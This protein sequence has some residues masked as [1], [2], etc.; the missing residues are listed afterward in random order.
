MEINQDFFK[1]IYKK[2]FIRTFNRVRP[3]INILFITPLNLNNNRI[4]KYNINS[5][6][7]VKFSIP[8]FES[9]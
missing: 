8:K 5:Y 7:S 6:F 4:F 1:T 2:R 9:L 3:V